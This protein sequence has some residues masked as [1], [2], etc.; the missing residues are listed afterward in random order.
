MKKHLSADLD[1]APSLSESLTPDVSARAAI[2]STASLLSTDSLRRP[3]AAGLLPPPDGG[4]LSPIT[5]LEK[6]GKKL[7]KTSL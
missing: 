6:V 2:R 1:L 7:K 5:G 3:R 4:S